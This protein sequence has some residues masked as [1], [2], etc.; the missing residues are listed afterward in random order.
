MRPMPLESAP[1]LA[2]PPVLFS[3]K[4]IL[5]GVVLLFV[6]GGFVWALPP[7]TLP[8]RASISSALLPAE[9][10][11]A[12]FIA[13]G[14]DATKS[15][16]PTASGFKELPLDGVLISASKGES[17]AAHILRDSAS[18]MSV[19]LDGTKL[20]G[21][22]AILAGVARSPK[23]AHVA[24]SATSEEGVQL[25][26]LSFLSNATVDPRDWYVTLLHPMSGAKAK[27]GSGV[28][29]VF[30]D[31]RHLLRVTARGIYVYDLQTGSDTLLLERDAKTLPL[32]VLA[33]P[34][35][36]LVGVRTI[37][38]QEVTIYRVSPEKAE[39]VATSQ[40]PK[41]VMSL[42]LGNN[43]LYVL[44]TSKWGTVISLQRVGEN[45]FK[46]VATIP[47]NI[48]ISRLLLGSL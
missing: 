27:V 16:V 46:T 4:H 25:P 43:G 42:A 21:T 23:G 10:K 39:V 38:A 2:P 24:F 18:G 20:T 41:R 11:S 47:E 22:P 34:D 35:R 29:P 13:E 19:V 15:Y 12:V 1:P 28:S 14:A 30:L 31:D 32:T 33:S 40:L 26:P 45:A 44:N 3:R 36:T 17:G 37:A 5:L 8:I 9:L 7:L 6:L 48:R